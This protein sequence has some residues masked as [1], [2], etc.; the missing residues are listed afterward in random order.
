MATDIH[1]LYIFCNTSKLPYS[2]FVVKLLHYNLKRFLD[3]KE[4]SGG[5]ENAVS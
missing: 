5:G 3:S 1:V 4:I 2:V